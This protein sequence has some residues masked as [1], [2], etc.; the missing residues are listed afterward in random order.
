MNSSAFLLAARCICPLILIAASV[1]ASAHRSWLLP[2]G[3]VLEGREPWVTIDAATSENLFDFD[4]NGNGNGSGLKL[5]GLAIFG[6]DGQPMLPLNVFNG[7]LR[8]SFDLKLA[9]AG[10]YK[11]SLNSKNVMVSYQLNGE[12]KRW[13][14]S[15]E[16]LAKAIPPGAGDVRTTRQYG[17]LETFVSAGKAD[18]RVL[19]ISGSGLEMQPLTHPNEMRS[20]ETA[21]WRFLFDGKPLA[22]FAFS[23]VPGGVRYRGVLNELR[24][25]TDANG[26][27]SVTLPNAGMVWLSASYLPDAGSAATPPHNSRRYSYAA[28]L[29][30]LPQ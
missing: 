30:I 24:L 7:A 1:P 6:P 12:S 13:R 25:S 19:K 5:D 27:A 17:R 23:L 3:T 26:D 2:S 18:S 16:E 4:G 15:E 9:K 8:N 28:T 10:T 21:R 22:N 29:E 11:V 14:G 20:G